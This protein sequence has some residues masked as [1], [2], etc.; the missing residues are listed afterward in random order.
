MKLFSIFTIFVL[1]FAV[2]A[3]AMADS[4]EAARM[5]GGRSFGSRPSMSQ[6]A[7]NPSSQQSRMGTAASPT[8][9]RSGMLG[10]MGGILGGVL[11]GTLLGSLLSGNGFAGGGGFMDIILLAILAFIAY[12]LFQRFRSRQAS[13]QPQGAGMPFG[14]NNNP[15]S[16]NGPMQRQDTGNLWNRMQNLGSGPANANPGVDVPADFNVQDFL[17]GAKMAYTRLQQSWD[18]RDLND[19]SRFATPSVISV[20]QEQLQADP[21]PSRTEILSVNASL[22]GVEDEGQTRRA[23]VFFDVMMREDPSN[24]VPENVREIWHF[25]RSNPS[26]GWMLDG[27]QQVR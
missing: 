12:K 23:Q 10:G 15:Y 3:L 22:V 14:G 9:Q 20:L 6:P 24:P 17:K 7:R 21:N 8:A 25:V 26:D 11:A 18:N 1:L 5:G 2:F 16:A 27:I 19:I 13:P 4:A